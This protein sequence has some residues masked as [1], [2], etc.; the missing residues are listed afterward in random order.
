[1]KTIFTAQH[2]FSI[3]FFLLAYF[4][5]RFARNYKKTAMKR[6]TSS[7]AQFGAPMIVGSYIVVVLLLIVA[8]SLLIG[9]LSH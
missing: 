9:P 2:I 5:F 3:I 1:M 7:T 4:Q 8:I 6:G